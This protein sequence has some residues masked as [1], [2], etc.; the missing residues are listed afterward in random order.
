MV[1]AFFDCYSGIAGDM[2]L[3]AL[4]DLGVEE[5]VFTCAGCQKTFEENYEQYDGNF[6]LVNYMTLLLQLIQDKKIVFS[7]KDQI[8]VTYHDPCHTTKKTESKIDYDTPRDILNLMPGVEFVEMKSH[9]EGSMC[10]GAGGGVKAA[11][12]DLAL[13]IAA[14]RFEEVLETNADVLLSSCPFCRRNLM[15]AAM[16]SKNGVQVMD[17][18]EFIQQ[19]M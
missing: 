1:V 13:K 19:R 4:I 18:I 9:K 16:M 3:G 11:N 8:K 7:K 14:T 17:I 6:K 15:D 5:I 10:C 12:P 2:I